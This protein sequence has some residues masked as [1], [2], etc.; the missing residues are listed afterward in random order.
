M[1]SWD[2]DFNARAKALN[3]QG[4]YNPADEKDACGV[5]LIAAID[6]KPRRSVVEM[7]ID[8]LKAL[9]HRGAVDAD[10]KTGD[11]AGIHIQIP[12]DFFKEHVQ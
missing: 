11:G 10:G 8:A 2:D 4:L 6:G 12:F 3:E 5:G 9:Y 1:Y 7:G